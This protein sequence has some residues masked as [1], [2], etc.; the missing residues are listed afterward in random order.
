MV[1]GVSVGRAPAIAVAS[2]EAHRHSPLI[3]VPASAS[4]PHVLSQLGSVS[5]PGPLAEN[6]PTVGI[7]VSLTIVVTNY[8]RAAHVSEHP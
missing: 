8:A 2:T 1:P 5:I 6:P 4:I 7:H 3:P